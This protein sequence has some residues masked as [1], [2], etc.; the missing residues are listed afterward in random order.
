MD[1]ANVEMAEE[2]GKENIFIFGMNVEEA[3]EIEQRRKNLQQDKGWHFYEKNEEL[4]LAV[5]QIRSNY[6][7][8]D[9]ENKSRWEGFLNELWNEDKYH[10]YA[11][12]EDYMRMQDQVGEAYM[13]I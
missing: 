5:D 12:Y 10:T 7:C 4:K 3:K 9:Y 13:V 11:D 1:G 8:M 6:F 2:M